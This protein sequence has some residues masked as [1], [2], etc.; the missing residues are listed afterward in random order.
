MK[1]YSTREVGELLDMPQE[2]VR[3]IARSGALEPERGPGLHYRFSFQD[4]IILR[5]ARELIAAGIGKSRVNRALFRLKTRLLQS[6]SLT[7]VRISGGDGE[8]M[9]R[10]GNQLFSAETG[11]L[12][13]NFTVS[14]LAGDVAPLAR[15]AKKEAEDSDRLTS[16]DWFDLG[17]DLEA[18][19]PEDA[20]GAYERALELDPY[21]ADAHVNLG[22]VQHESGKL[23]EAESHYR[24]AL[25]TEPE[26]VLAA[27]NLGTLLED[28]GRIQEAITEYKKAPSFAD[29]HY[30]LSRLY[31]LVGQHAEALKHLRTYRTLIDPK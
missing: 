11:Q 21:H 31:E 15:K 5:T 13:F 19:S 20:P 27:F 12:Q 24:R 23:E 26:N 6:K 30:N 1:G 4:I 10:D 3:E 22:R 7:S 8:V 28:L 17:V 9:V 18:V 16:D 29:A 25:T 14:E 2:T